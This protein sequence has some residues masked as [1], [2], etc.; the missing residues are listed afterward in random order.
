VALSLR[1]FPKLSAV[2]FGLESHFGALS[3]LTISASVLSLVA[4]GLGI[5][6]GGQQLVLAGA[7]GLAA[8]TLLLSF[9]AIEEPWLAAGAGVLGVAA[10]ATLDVRP[11]LAF[12]LAQAGV[13]ALFLTAG[14]LAWSPTRG[15][16]DRTYDLFSPPRGPRGIPKPTEDALSTTASLLAFLGLL[17]LCFMSI[18]R[19]F[20]F[21][22]LGVF[23]SAWAPWMAGAQVVTALHQLRRRPMLASWHGLLVAI[24]AA[25]WLLFSMPVWNYV[26]GVWALSLVLL[27]WATRSPRGRRV[28]DSLSPGFSDAQ[29]ENLR[30]TL[31]A[32]ATATA[33]LGLQALHPEKLE[34]PVSW[35]LLTATFA[36]QALLGSGFGRA[37]FLLALPFA[38]HYAA[39]FVGIKLDTGRPQEVILPYVAA[40]MA[41]VALL[42]ER[43]GVWRKNRGHGGSG[44]VAAHLYGMLA[45]CEWA[46]SLLVVR[47]AHAEV[48]ACF[49]AGASLTLLWTLRA[50]AADSKLFAWAAEL[51]FLAVYFSLRMQTDWLG[52]RGMRGDKDSIATLLLGVLFVGLHTAVKKLKVPAFRQPSRFAALALPVLSALLMARE[53]SY[54][55]AVLLLG[56]AMQ[57]T[58]LSWVEGRGKLS[59]ILAAVA[60]NLAL[61][62]VWLT[63]GIGG[64]ADAQY[65]VIPAGFTLIVLTYLYGESLG[66]AWKA[67]LR[68]VGMLAIYLSSAIPALTF[69]SPG[70]LW[71]AIGLC[72]LGI[73]AGIAF[74]VRAYLYLGTGFMVASLVTN[75]TRYGLRD[76]RVGA[77]FL[78]G[79]GLVIIVAMVFFTSRREELLGR[80]R[81]YR[82][83]MAAWE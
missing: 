54:G 66:P 36:L 42:S 55:N 46:A 7:L 62:M 28:V 75:M 11:E 52:P 13:N 69:E 38:V 49:V 32:Y 23:E 37:M 60:F 67:R 56:V 74:R 78:T 44:I 40:A 77:A 79:L 43:I 8:A 50:L 18:W 35:A 47:Y 82:Q 10:L 31:S 20:A 29:V 27:A 65:Y 24:L 70:Y 4:V 19:I 51:S 22:P 6:W 25:L 3:L 33:F 80:Y 26:A 39:F 64:G 81:K 83:L 73:V 21:G 58:V 12:L 2:L 57:L 5:F 68:S 1:R 15:L 61:A 34:S 71:T 63:K 9:L 41:V 76:H 59:G 53:A 16:L 45:A 17:V 30:R 72:V 48:G 14:A